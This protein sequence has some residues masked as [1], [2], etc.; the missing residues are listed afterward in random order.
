MKEKNAVQKAAVAEIMIQTK[1]GPRKPEDRV[2][3]SHLT[4]PDLWHSFGALRG[5]AEAINNENETASVVVEERAKTLERVA[6]LAQET[7]DVAHDMRHALQ[8]TVAPAVYSTYDLLDRLKAE[9]K[10]RRLTAED[11]QLAIDSLSRAFQ[12]GQ[13][14]R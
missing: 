9:S 7:W 10:V 11:L 3:V 13:H 8:E 5:I 4:V 12:D 14:G 2:P 6:D 1:R